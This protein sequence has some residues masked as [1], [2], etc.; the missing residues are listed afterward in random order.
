LTG[1]M[2]LLVLA[3]AAH[4][5]GPGQERTLAFFNIHTQEH[6]TVIYRR[7]DDYVPEA[8]AKINHILRDTIGGE[9][10]PIDPG[11][12]DFLYDLLEKAGYHQEV[13]V[14]CGYRSPQTNTMLHDRTSGVALG[15]LHTK[16]RAID[17]RLPGVDTKKLYNIA[18]SMNRGGTGYYRSSD[19][20]QI[21]TGP[22]RFW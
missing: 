18:K 14:V 16:G 17:L 2:F 19:F 8:L 1:V 7:G 4:A 13:H 6:L 3:A 22:V 11:L 20:I 10:H 12:L 9:E 5:P 15:S 21:D